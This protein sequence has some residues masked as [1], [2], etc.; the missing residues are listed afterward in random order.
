MLEI[1][2]FTYDEYNTRTLLMHFVQRKVSAGPSR[3]QIKHSYNVNNLDEPTLPLRN[4]FFLFVMSQYQY[5]R[6]RDTLINS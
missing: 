2:N 4:I 3:K 6:P 5:A 1:H